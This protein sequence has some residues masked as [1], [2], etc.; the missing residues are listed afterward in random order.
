MTQNDS[1]S[2]V[3]SDAS[4]VQERHRKCDKMWGLCRTMSPGREHEEKSLKTW[5]CGRS[6]INNSLV[7]S[8]DLY[9]IPNA[10]KRMLTQ[11]ML[12][13]STRGFKHRLSHRKCSQCL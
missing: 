6:K 8:F 9:T 2:Q 5:Y 7:M 3:L 4:A 11:K 1:M 13:E 10:E 12:T